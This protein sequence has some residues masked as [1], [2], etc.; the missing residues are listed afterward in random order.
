MN[1]FEAE[2]RAGLVVSLIFGGGYISP[3]AQVVFKSTFNI[4]YNLN[5]ADA[6][7]VCDHV[8]AMCRAVGTEATEVGFEDN[9]TE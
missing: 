7:A 9:S 2:R 1:H 5:E 4:I 8:I 3:A 6:V